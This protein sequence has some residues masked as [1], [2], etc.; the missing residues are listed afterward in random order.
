VQD[1]GLSRGFHARN[2]C[3]LFHLESGEHNACREDLGVLVLFC[4]KREAV[5]VN[6]QAGGKEALHL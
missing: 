4:P 6:E 5:L 3:P 1:N 2:R